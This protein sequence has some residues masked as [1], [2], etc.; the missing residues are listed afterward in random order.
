MDSIIPPETSTLIPVLANF[1]ARVDLLYVVKVF[2]THWN[3]NEIYAPP[4]SLMS[5][6]SPKIH[7]SNFSTS[8][9]VISVGQVLGIGRNP[10]TWLGGMEK[11]S[12]EQQQAIND[13]GGLIQAL[14]AR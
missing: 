4:D 12:L 8:P 7:V 9:V 1:P 3:E 5:R 2:S 14:V 6:N 10:G 11:F 13:H